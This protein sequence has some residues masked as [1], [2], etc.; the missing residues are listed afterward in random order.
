MVKVVKKVNGD[1]CFNTEGA[2]GKLVNYVLLFC[3]YFVHI[4]SYS[5][6]YVVS[7]LYFYF[8]FILC[9]F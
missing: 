5:I 2:Q 3:F 1:K 8:V 7:N 6:S 4:L 9:M